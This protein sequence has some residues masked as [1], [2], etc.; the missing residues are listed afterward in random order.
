MKEQVC[1]KPVEA[2]GHP[3]LGLLS[4]GHR[5]QTVGGKELTDCRKRTVHGRQQRWPVTEPGQVWI[6]AELG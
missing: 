4:A 5:V 3:C 1:G 2:E 6:W